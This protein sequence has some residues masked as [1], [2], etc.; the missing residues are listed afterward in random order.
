MTKTA[1]KTVEKTA[2][3]KWKDQ[4][5]DNR[6]LTGKGFY[7]SYLNPNKISNSLKT[8]ILGTFDV[9]SE[10]LGVKQ[11]RRIETALVKGDSFLILTGDF[12]K[13]YEKVL[14]KGYDA[15]LKVYK[16]NKAK[17]RNNWSTDG[18]A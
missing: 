4:G 1:K 2:G 9:M 14:K 11:Y 17:H 10:L 3:P 18:Q 16:S 8:G 15:C 5:G 12:R 6:I 13:E 7:I